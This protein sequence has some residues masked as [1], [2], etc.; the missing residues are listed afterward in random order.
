MH[1]D[2]RGQALA[3]SFSTTRVECIKA[4]NIPAL[5]RLLRHEFLAKKDN[6]PEE[7]LKQ[8]A[9]LVWKISTIT[10]ERGK[11]SK[12]PY[13]PRSMK[14]RQGKQGSE[15]DK[16]N[17]GT[18]DDAIKAF[19]EDPDVAGI[20]FALLPEFRIVALDVDHCI[21]D[22]IIRDDVT[23]LTNFTYCEI[24]PS[25][26]GIRAFWIG[27]ANDCKNHESGFELFHSIGFVTLTGNQVENDHIAVETK[28]LPSL[29]LDLDL[30]TTLE[31]LCRNTNI[32]RGVTKGIN[33]VENLKAM[34]TSDPRL[35]A[36]IAAGLYERDMDNGKHS[37]TCPFEDQHSDYGRST[38]DADT[39][40]FQPNTNGYAEGHIHCL[41]S[42]GNDQSAYWEKIGYN[43]E[44]ELF[45]SLASEDWP[46]P[47][48]L[49]DDLPAVPKLDLNLL[50]GSLRPWIEDI[51]ERMQTPPDIPAIGAI[52]ALSAAIG[53][54]VQIH[55]KEHDDWTVVPNLWG[56]AVAPPGFMKSPALAEVMR[57]LIRLEQEAYE[58]FIRNHDR[59]EVEKEANSTARKA[60]KAAAINRLKKDPCAENAQYIADP[61]EPI[62]RRYCVNNFSMEAL[63]EVLAGNPNGVLAFSDEIQGLL[64]MTQKIGNEGLND[65]LLSA[66]NGDGSYVFDRIGRGLNRRVPY[67]CMSILGGIQPGRLMEHVISATQ[68]GAG[69]SGLIQRFQLMVWPDMAKNWRRVDREPNRE[70]QENAIRIFRKATGFDPGRNLD[71]PDEGIYGTDIRRF[72]SKAQGEFFDWLETLEHELRSDT[73]SPVMISH[74]SKYRSLVPSLALIFA[75]S[76]GADGSITLEHLQQ[77][78]GWSNYLRRHAE[79]V[80]ACAT[81][82]DSRHARALLAKITSRA[83]DDGFS[84]RDIYLKGWQFLDRDGVTKALNLL[85]DHGYLQGV[86][87]ALQPLGGRPSTSYRIHPC[88]KN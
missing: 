60:A 11:F 3:T 69:D 87:K 81:R 8:K 24:S 50:P 25:G 52:T 82:P 56:L 1:S 32:S 44:N 47:H 62:A 10:P 12:I 27:E 4:E 64:A 76:D 88:L 18:W 42:H 43:P 66:W 30:R 38:G 54:R 33:T 80:Y 73:L 75:V 74:L 83:I 14:K 17:L 2:M 46:D 68:G 57:P 19:H 22:G 86:K 41:H 45:D 77:A 29:D 16:K 85:C 40:Y 61:D 49:P 21:D 20:G 23:R 39:V 70:A 63:G 37:I 34:A 84:A 35:K 15:D 58:E 7:L 28:T 26:R 78:I 67:V 31:T 65:F 5:T 9:C 36:I 13:Y 55:P 71:S 6:I 48:P 53:R 72:E 59:W 79:R 51:A